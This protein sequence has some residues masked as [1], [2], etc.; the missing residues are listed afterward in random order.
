MNRATFI[1]S[2]FAGLLGSPVVA[3][4]IKETEPLC[5]P[6]AQIIGDEIEWTHAD[7]IKWDC[8]W[9]GDRLIQSYKGKDCLIYRLD[10]RPLRFEA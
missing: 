4:A 3:K 5:L 1:K 8:R 6:P 7:D 2:L 9:E 10:Q